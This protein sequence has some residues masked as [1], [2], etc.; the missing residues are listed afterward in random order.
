MQKQYQVGEK[1]ERAAVAEPSYITFFQL[2][3]R[4]LC[5]TPARF[6]RPAGYRDNNRQ[7]CTSSIII[8]IIPPSSS[9]SPPS[10]SP[11]LLPASTPADTG[12]IW[13]VGVW[14]RRIFLRQELD[15]YRQPRRRGGEIVTPLP[16]LGLRLCLCL[17][18]GRSLA[19]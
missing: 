4:L 3:S 12:R 6:Q 17:A 19:V 7:Y 5:T 11:S 16:F 13:C 10:L 1:G 9:L 8:M 2:D 15:A 18:V 14:R